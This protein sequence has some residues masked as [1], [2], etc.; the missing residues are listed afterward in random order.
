MPLATAPAIKMPGIRVIRPLHE[1]S[2]NVQLPQPGEPP[3]TRRICPETSKRIYSHVELS[4]SAPD[5]EALPHLFKRSV[6]LQYRLRVRVHINPF[7]IS[8]T[9]IFH[10][11]ALGLIACI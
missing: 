1:R 11:P 7:H 2:Q 4:T 5:V 6:Q 3:L 9:M 10:L 8:D